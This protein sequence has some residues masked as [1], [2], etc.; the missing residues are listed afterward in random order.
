MIVLIPLSRFRIA[1][2]VAA[3][4]PFSQ[5]ERL[6]L[7]AIAEGANELTKLKETFQ[8]HPRLLVEALVTLTHAGWLS[9]GRAGHEGFV[10]TSEGTEAVTS[11]RPPSTT[12]VTS[13]EAQVVMERVTGSI[14]S[15]RDVR[16]VSRRELG[17]LWF[18]TIRLS[19]QVT[20]NRLDEGQVQHL[21]PQKQGEWVRWIGPID[22]LSKNVHWLPVNVDLKVGSVEGLP[23]QWRSRLS[24]AIKAEARQSARLLAAKDQSISWPVVERRRSPLTSHDGDLESVRIPP[25]V[26]QST[27]N[28]DDFCFT[29]EEHEQLLANVFREAQ[30]SILITSAFANPRRL[31]SLRKKMEAA[32]RRGVNIDLIWGYAAS[33][34]QQERGLLS[35]LGRA[36]DWARRNGQ[37][38][39]RFNRQPANTHGK[40][41]LWDGPVGVAACVGSN[42]WLSTL[43]VQAESSVRRNVTLRIYEPAIVAAI[44]RC[45]A[46]Y[47][48]AVESEILSSTADR[49]SRIAADL[50]MVAAHRDTSVTNAKVSLILDREHETL[51]QDSMRTAQSRLFVA[52]HRLGAVSRI[53]LVNSDVVRPR[54][55]DFTVVY[56]EAGEN[57]SWLSEVGELVRKNGGLFKGV[58]GF[59]GKAL[60]CD[61]CA[62]VTSYNFLSAD[63]FGTST[64]A[65]EIGLVIEGKPSA[66]WVWSQLNKV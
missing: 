30:R 52:S 64:N 5:L 55:L 56:G 43:V 61:A 12:V 60:I 28:N 65:R 58:P 63:P 34:F 27:I 2:E 32:L 42:N 57:P 8:V 59:H 31:E 3:G 53:R 62:C 22:M 36:A 26:W 39:L 18:Q 10:L 20:A 41:L 4:R 21:L 38:I 66:D 7:R 17:D 54:D 51:L 13:R 23:D 46:G 19:S 29:T 14:V 16:F 25:R 11:D 49:W 15:N 48:S 37:G 40:V 35:W 9:I 45:A 44:A 6:I 47:W 1:Y 33:D 50:D 24:A